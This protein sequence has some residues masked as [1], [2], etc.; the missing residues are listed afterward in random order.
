MKKLIVLALISASAIVVWRSNDEGDRS[1]RSIMKDRIWIDHMPR[2]ERDMIDVLI[3]LEEHP[4]GAFQ[5]TSAWQGA[6]EAFRYEASG[7]EMRIFFP[8]S[9]DNEKLRVEARTCNERGMDYCLE[10]SGSKRGATRYYSRK[11][12]E[13][14]SLGE[15]QKK[16]DALT[17]AD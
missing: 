3:V 10:V 5:K 15:V 11:G 8:Q 1:A 4:V 17:T 6:F 13:I 7:N 14:R 9:G 16:L 12:W 2:N